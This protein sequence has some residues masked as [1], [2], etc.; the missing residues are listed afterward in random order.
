MNTKRAYINPNKTCLLNPNFILIS[1]TTL[2][3]N[4]AKKGKKNS[5]NINL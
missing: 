4:Y 1:K 5:S 2:L 3:P